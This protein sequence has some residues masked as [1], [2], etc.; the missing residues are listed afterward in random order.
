MAVQ[1][2]ADIGK[3]QI[4]SHQPPASQ[5][6]FEQCWMAAHRLLLCKSSSSRCNGFIVMYWDPGQWDAGNSHNV[7]SFPAC[8]PL[9]SH[10]SP[11]LS[12][13]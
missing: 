7:C 3:S 10:T 6:M 12:A 9:H 2:E 8:S 11:Y 5:V 1:S 4:W 13:A